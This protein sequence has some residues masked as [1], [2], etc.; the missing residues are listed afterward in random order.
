MVAFF[1]YLRE[2]KDPSI[3]HVFLNDMKRYGALGKVI[4]S[5][6]RRESGLTKAQ[7]EMLGAFV[8]GL[9][10]CN[11]CHNVHIHFGAARA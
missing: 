8:S 10:E 7:R 6:M 9:N 4:N 2:K 5:I 11:F 3:H 1:E